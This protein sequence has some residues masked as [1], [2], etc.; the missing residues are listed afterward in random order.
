MSTPYYEVQNPPVQPRMYG[1]FSTAA[2]IFGDGR[3][4]FAG[5]T[6]E[7]DGCSQARLVDPACPPTGETGG[8]TS[9]Q[10]QPR[11]YV[12]GSPFIVYA[13]VTCGP[14]ANPLPEDVARRRLAL[15]EQWRVER[16]VWERQLATADAVE[17]TG[18]A[19]AVPVVDAVA[20]LE[21]ALANL[22]GGQGVIHVPVRAAAHL[23]AAQL[24]ERDGQMKR[25]TTIGTP[26][27]VGGGYPGTGT[28]GSPPTAGQMHLYATGPVVV[29]RSDVVVPATLRS[30]ALNTSTNQALVVAERTYAVTTDCVLLH[31]LA[32]LT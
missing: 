22:F 31:V 28:D 19:T 32:D 23:A 24:I 2:V 9:L 29:R 26:V 15:G 6:S 7:T 25:T 1:L 20:A 14:V 13:G 11:T 3:W 4:M 8:D 17:A 27:A 16:T 10:G 5:V 12:N 30:G 21:Q 18:A